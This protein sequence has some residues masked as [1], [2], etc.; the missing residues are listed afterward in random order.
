MK[1]DNIG[2]FAPEHKGKAVTPTAS[3]KL[4][5]LEVEGVEPSSP[6]ACSECGY[7]KK[8]HGWTWG[9]RLN[10]YHYY[11]APNDELRLER[12]LKRRSKGKE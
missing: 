3:K 5:Q 10:T 12:M 7:S 2:R 6:D 8:V 9:N 4:K 1:R 11:I